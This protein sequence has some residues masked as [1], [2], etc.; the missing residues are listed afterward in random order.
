MV[1]STTLRARLYVTKGDTAAKSDVSKYGPGLELQSVASQVRRF[2][3]LHALT[4][5]GA[6][7]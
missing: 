1:A 2:V 3:S 6:D 5:W 7:T 4:S